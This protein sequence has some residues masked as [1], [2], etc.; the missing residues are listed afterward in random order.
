M[1]PRNS[2]EGQLSLLSKANAVAF[3]YG[4]DFRQLLEPVLQKL[5]VPAHVIPSKADWLDQPWIEFPFV[6]NKSLEDLAMQPALALHTS[7]STGIPKPV[8]LKHG[9]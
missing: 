2:V 5:T 1:S 6:S 7:G 4:E 3:F 8:D 9:I